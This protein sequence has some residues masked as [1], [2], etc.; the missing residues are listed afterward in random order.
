MRSPDPQ[1]T[2]LLFDGQASWTSIVSIVAQLA[3]LGLYLRGV[4]RLAAAGRHWPNLKLVSFVVGMVV[5]AYATEGGIAHY[6]TTNFTAHVVQLFVLID[7]VPPL[8]AMGAPV[9]LALQSASQP[10]GERLLRA[11]HSRVALALTHP[12]VVFAAALGT[13]FAYFLSPLYSLSE[14]HP[15]LLAYVHWHFVMVGAL[16]WWVVVNRDSL[17]RPRGFGARFVLVL[18]SVPLNAA[19]GLAL[20]SVSKPLYPAGNTLAD[21]QAGGNVLLGLTEVFIVAVLALLFVEWAREEERRA[22]RADRQLDAAMAAARATATDAGAAS[23]GGL[24]ESELERR[25]VGDPTL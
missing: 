15:V 20:A 25:E 9:R 23:S 10:A 19:L 7:V 11:L 14:R 16:L 6:Q 12:A 13:M 2:T 22:V 8:L 24:P 17:P 18:V 4:R 5:L 21:T 3:A 1:L